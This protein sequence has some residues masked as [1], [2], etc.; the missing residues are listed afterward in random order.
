MPD[1]DASSPVNSIAWWDHYFETRWE[2]NRGRE[3]SRYFMEVLIAGL[4]RFVRTRLGRGVVSILDWGCALGDGT[5]V[6]AEQFSN[7]S[8]QGFDSSAAAIGAAATH[9]PRL[10]FRLVGRDCLDERYD[11]VFCSNT[12]EH[13]REPLLI[14]EQQLLLARLYHVLLVPYNEQDR[15]ESHMATLCEDSFPFQIGGFRK[16]HETVI[17]TSPEFWA[18]SQLL[19]VYAGPE[20]FAAT[21]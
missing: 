21:P 20:I 7:A 16:V 17:E 9:Y 12:L 18:G 15:E 14:L 4:P 1:R 2:A 8:V 13:F 11:A 10:Q 6:I 19:I 5:Q 3:Q